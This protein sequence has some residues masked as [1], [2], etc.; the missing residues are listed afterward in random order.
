[1]E[2]I[3]NDLLTEREFLT[4]HQK[5]SKN[6]PRRKS[7]TWCSVYTNFNLKASASHNDLKKYYFRV[8]WKTY[9][10]LDRSNSL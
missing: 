7:E 8:L 5:E 3:D 9:S 4:T 6:K 2:E 1:M 10:I